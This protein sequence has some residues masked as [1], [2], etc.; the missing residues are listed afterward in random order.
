MQFPRVPHRR[1]QQISAPRVCDSLSDRYGVLSA[2]RIY[3]PLGD[4][5]EQIQ[6]L[7]ESA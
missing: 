6:C 4:A 5:A 3:H 7:Y 2:H 1:D